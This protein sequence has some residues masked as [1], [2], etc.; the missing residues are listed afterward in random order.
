MLTLTTIL[1]QEDALLNDLRLK[2]KI[3]ELKQEKTELLDYV[4]TFNKD[5]EKEILDGTKKKQLLLE[6]GRKLGKTDEE[7]LAEHGKF[8]PSIQTP[9]LN[10]LYFFMQDDNS[11]IFGYDMTAMKNSLNDQ[12]GLLTE[13]YSTEE[14][15]EVPDFSECIYG[16]ITHDTFKKMKKLK[17]LSQSDNEN[18]AFAAYTACMKLCKKHNL[19]FDKIPNP[20]GTQFLNG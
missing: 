2:K 5:Y 20:A 11:K 9:L 3:Q 12:I 19:D 14:Q 8:L 16:D 17:A 10:W 6:D 7:I 13:N 18:E 4:N 1:S 15:N